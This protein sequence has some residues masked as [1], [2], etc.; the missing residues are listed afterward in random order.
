MDVNGICSTLWHTLL[1]MNISTQKFL[2]KM[3]VSNSCL[4]IPS[5][6]AGKWPQNSL[7][8]GIF[9]FRK[10]RCGQNIL[11][12]STPDRRRFW[13]G[14]SQHKAVHSWL[15]LVGKVGCAYVRGG[16]GTEQLSLD[17]VALGGIVT[18]LLP[19]VT[20]FHGHSGCRVSGSK[21]KIANNYDECLK[22]CVFHD[23][24]L[25]A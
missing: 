23:I 14:C 24:M 18:Y 10:I 12:P 13:N 21:G 15:V 1:G 4:M 6:F 3:N 7:K 8:F 11:P 19:L 2:Q 9:F 22:G 16:P 25:E 20:M 17:I 5:R